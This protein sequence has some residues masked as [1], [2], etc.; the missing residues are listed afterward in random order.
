ME[1]INVGRVVLGGLLAGLILNIGEFILNEPILGKEWA[2]TMESM[3]RPAISSGAIVCF[4][5]MTFV[6]GIFT[7]CLYAA[8]RPRFGPGPKT[9]ILAGLSVWF[10]TALWPAVG[11]AAMGL[12]PLRL[13]VIGIVWGFFELPLAA[14]A[15]AWLYRE[16]EPL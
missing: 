5:L 4:V 10:L 2:S 16:E 11:F 3:N 14:L 12:F 8:I 7:V 13:L 15:G 1:N 6:L 9:A